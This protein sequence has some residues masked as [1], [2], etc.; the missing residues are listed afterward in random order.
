QT[1]EFS[2]F[3]AAPGS[4]AEPHPISRISKGQPPDSAVSDEAEPLEVTSWVLF[5]T[6]ETDRH[7]LQTVVTTQNSVS[8]KSKRETRSTTD[9]RGCSPC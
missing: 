4:C 1:R 9:V 8:K 7:A 2:D 3:R 6:Y 5:T